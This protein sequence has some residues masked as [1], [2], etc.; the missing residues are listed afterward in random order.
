MKHTRDWDKAQE[1]TESRLQRRK[2][3]SIVGI[4]NGKI[5]WSGG[6]WS[7]IKYYSVNMH[8]QEREEGA[9]KW[10]RLQHL[11]DR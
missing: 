1:G 3:W 7:S 2:K 10:N 8:A 4:D 9:K 11:C 5:F 6:R